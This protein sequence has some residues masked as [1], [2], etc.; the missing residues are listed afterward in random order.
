MNANAPVILKRHDFRNME[1]IPFLANSARFHDVVKGGHILRHNVLLRG[2]VVIAGGAA[3]GTTIGENPGNLLTRFI[4]H[5]NPHGDIKNLMPR[6]VLR[7]RVFDYG[8]ADLDAA[9]TGAAGTFALNQP[10]TLHHALPRSPISVETALWTSGLGAIQLEIQCGS[11]DTQFTGNDRAFDFTAVTLDVVDAREIMPAATSLIIETDQVAVI[12]GASARFRISDIPTGN[13]LLSGLLMAESTAAQTLVD[14]ILNSI[15]VGSGT[16][17]FM[18]VNANDVRFD[19]RRFT[20]LPQGTQSQAGLY[21]LPFSPDLTL[22]G[23]IDVRNL[24]QVVAELDV[25]NPG[26]AGLDRVTLYTRE[27]KFL[28][29]MR[30]T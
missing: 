16:I 19:A 20:T 30:L 29:D 1:R 7:Q 2:N 27:V 3:N 15:R 22:K 18:D 26:G 28:E 21:F 11:R 14:T 6:S 24:S 8:F 25:A 13:R 10:F 17:Q 12:A 9:L 5:A 4:L 23:A